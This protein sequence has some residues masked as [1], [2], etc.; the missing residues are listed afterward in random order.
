VQVRVISTQ[1]TAADTGNARVMVYPN[2]VG[3]TLT[4]QF[5]D[6]TTSGK[7]LLKII[8]MNGSVVQTQETQVT[9]GQLIYVNVSGL[10]KGVYALQVIVGTKQTYQ[11]IVKQ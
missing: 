3:S 1:R 4:V 10:A 6:Q 9:G 8:S 5:T 2:P 11:L 7:A